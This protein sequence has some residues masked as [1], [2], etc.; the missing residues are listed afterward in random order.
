[1]HQCSAFHRGLVAVMNQSM[2]SL[3]VQWFAECR[4]ELHRQWMLT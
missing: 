1:M 4:C 3:I 2:E